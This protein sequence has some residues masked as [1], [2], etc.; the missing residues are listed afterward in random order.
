MDAFWTG[1]SVPRSCAIIPYAAGSH[2]DVFVLIEQRTAGTLNSGY[3]MPAHQAWV[4]NNEQYAANF[5]EKSKLPL[6]P[7]KK[8]AIVT[9]MDA[10]INV[11]AELGV[12]EGDAHIIRN[13]GGSAKDALRSIIISQRL[14]GTREIAVFHHTDCGM[15]TFTTP[16]LRKLVKDSDP[17]NPSLHAVDEIDFLEFH[18]LD[19]SIKEDV[20]YLKTSPL[21]LK[22]T[23]ITGW[24]YE[25]GTGKVLT[26]PTTLYYTVLDPARRLGAMS[27]AQSDLV[28]EQS[29]VHTGV[30]TPRHLAAPGSALGALHIPTDKPLIAV[31]MDDVLSQTNRVVAEWHNDTYGTRITLDDFYY[32]YYWKNP[33]WGTPEE[34]FKKVEDF[35]QT[36]RLDRALPIEG[37]R[38]GLLKL[39]ELGFRMVVVTARQRRELE[40][41]MR[42]IETHFAGIFEDMICTGQSQETLAEE[43]EVLTKL[44]KAD[45]CLQLGAKFLIDDS[46]ENALKCIKHPQPTQVLLFGNN[47][48][49]KREASY[50]DIKDELS[51]E[52]RL[53]KEGGREFWKE[54]EVE[55]PAH[56]PLTRVP[57]WEGV[58]AWAEVAL[59]EGR[60]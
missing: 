42:W 41:S 9:C 53:K 47:A 13:A 27:A 3:N 25:V 29:H 7:A 36:D 14:L 40:R 31:D 12:N 18:E 59:R 37:A 26:M 56:L 39:R 54:E 57:D 33:G 28:V 46:L 44:S 51:F 52:E 22:E 30:D 45:V 49:N 8:V 4:A 19:K 10:R 16:Q 38:E 21:V 5:G 60:I 15:L 55:I 24:V 35:Y 48:W 6:P 32:Y 43:H 1:W 20:E 50:K 58:V 34:T 11:Y 23:V 17:S 2:C